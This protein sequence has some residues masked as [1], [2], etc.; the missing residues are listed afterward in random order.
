MEGIGTYL[1]LQEKPAQASG[2]LEPKK[3]GKYYEEIEQ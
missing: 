1:T 2:T 3:K